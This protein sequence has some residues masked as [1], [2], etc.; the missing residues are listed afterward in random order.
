M[1]FCQRNYDLKCH[2]LIKASVVSFCLQHAEFLFSVYLPS[3]V[4]PIRSRPLLSPY[5]HLSPS[6]QQMGEKQELEDESERQK[7]AFINRKIGF[8][9]RDI[10]LPWEYENGNMPSKFPACW[11][12][13]Q[14]IRELQYHKELSVFRR[15]RAQKTAALVSSCKLFFTSKSVA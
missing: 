7:T 14:L 15:R 12:V 13:N 2:F 10:Y 9:G 8:Q 5:T 3:T 4:F 6:I 1:S 11:S